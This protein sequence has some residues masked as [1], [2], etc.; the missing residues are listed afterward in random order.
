MVDVVLFV[1]VP[2]PLSPSIKLYKSKLAGADPSQ[3]SGKVA[4]GVPDS[5]AGSIVIEICSVSE[6]VPLSMV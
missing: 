1:H 6:H 2:V 4:T 5:G 3:N